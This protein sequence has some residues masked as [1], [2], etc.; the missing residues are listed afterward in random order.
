[1]PTPARCLAHF[2]GRCVASTAAEG[3]A[4][5]SPAAEGCVMVN[6]DSMPVLDDVQHRLIELIGGVTIHVADA[7][8]G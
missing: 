4:I 8:P 7:G 2:S 3:L 1:M 5:G 6:E